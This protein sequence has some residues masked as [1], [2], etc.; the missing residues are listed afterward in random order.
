VR[1]ARRRGYVRLFGTVTPAAAGARV[2]FEC[3]DD[4]GRYELV[5]GTLARGGSGISRFS[6]AVRLHR[7][8]LYRALAQVTSG[9]Q[10][11]GRSQ[12]VMIR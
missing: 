8:G 7:H 9:A 12:P 3:K 10:V 11:S 5:S 1:P 4:S 6:R 2:A